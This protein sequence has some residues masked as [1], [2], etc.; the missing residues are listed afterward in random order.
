[1]A[2]GWMVAVADGVAEGVV[3]VADGVGLGFGVRVGRGVRVAVGLGLGVGSGVEVAVGSGV[4]VTVG[5]GVP[6]T[7]DVGVDVTWLDR[8]EACAA[9]EGILTSAMEKQSKTRHR[10]AATTFTGVVDSACQQR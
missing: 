3:A 5:L 4:E 9:D 10:S 6:P 1:M 2:V 8:F 7:G